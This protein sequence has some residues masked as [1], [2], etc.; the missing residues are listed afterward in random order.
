MPLC[1][2]G[3]NDNASSPGLGRL[4]AL[5]APTG[6]WHVGSAHQPVRRIYYEGPRG[7][8]SVGGM[9]PRKQLLSLVSQ[10]PEIFKCVWG[11][12]VPGGPSTHKQPAWA[13]TRRQRGAAR[14]SKLPSP[15]ALGLR[16]RTE[17]SPLLRSE[18]G[19][20]EKELAPSLVAQQPLQF[21]EQMH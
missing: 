3:V 20:C 10:I 2:V 16:W 6:A 7:S 19:E 11:W 8:H 5:E 1:R 12:T 13:E 21:C 15:R 17:K 18:P 9:R 4:R 14:E